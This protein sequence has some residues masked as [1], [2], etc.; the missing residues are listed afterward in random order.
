LALAVLGEV[1]R[2]GPR[3]AE[4]LAARDVQALDPR[5]RAFLHELVMG[6]LRR[7]G[8]LD[9]AITRLLDK[10]FAKLPPATRDV[11]RLGAYQVLH[12]RVP[13]R[14]A[15]AESVELARQEAPRTT[16]LVNAV[17]RRLSREGAARAPDPDREPV[18]WLTSEGSLPPWLADRWVRR[19]GAA[20]A[21]ARA[22]AF[23]E[24]PPT[25]F[26]FNPRVPDVEARVIAAGV[27]P[28]RLPVPGAWEADA[29]A[30]LIPLAA[31]G[32][33][34]LQDQASQLV[35]HLAAGHGVRL[36]ACAAP[37]GKA[38]LMADLAGAQG[39]VV[40]ADA[41]ARRL[42]TMAGAVSAWGAENLRLAGAD[43]LR[44]PFRPAFDAV[45]LDAPCSGLGTLGRHPDIR[46]RA[47]PEDIP[48]HA[49]R[50]QRLLDALS[51]LVRPGGRLV[52]S[53]CSA[54]PEEG[55]AVLETFLG[56]RSD[57]IPATL[58][59]W[60]APFGAGPGVCATRPETHG[61]D[62]FFVA[63]LDRV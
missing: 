6:T 49:A 54:E 34:Y 47:R 29:A 45:L 17:L 36:D 12:L 40:A 14:A 7:R 60:A 4:R 42:K 11:L 26:R 50:Q 10:P 22:R 30:R 43:G 24:E 38:L 5:D 8:A 13:D 3:L 58:P 2:G 20:A 18:A 55:P 61:G 32:A 16:G 15:V 33:V 41:S 37:G 46:W 62:A 27:E 48:R 35:A 51:A 44:P 59:A 39:R 28:R 21:V 56:G 63:A 1:T 19:L 57:L 52:Y 9:G 53:V 31:D 25:A 23:L